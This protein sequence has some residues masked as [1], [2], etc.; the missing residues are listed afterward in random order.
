MEPAVVADLADGR[1]VVVYRNLNAAKRDP[2]VFIWSVAFATGT[3][4][5]GKLIGHVTE[6]TLDDVRCVV[7]QR[8]HRIRREGG[9]REVV[10]WLAGY[11]STG[12]TA[13]DRK[14]TFDLYND[15]FFRAD[16]TRFDRARTAR[17]TDK[18]AYVSLP[19][20]TPQDAML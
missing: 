16:G 15:C 18:G 3:D 2:K 6:L 9:H 20:C 12:F 14:V 7:S 17:V 1:R 19:N 10:A 13:A 5:C 4:G 11:P 8:A